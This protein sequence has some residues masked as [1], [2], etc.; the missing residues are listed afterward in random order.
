[1]IEGSIFQEDITFINIYAPNIRAPKYMKQILTELKIERDSSKIILGNFITSISIMYWTKRPMI[2]MLI[3][4]LN[5]TIDQLDLTEIY[6]ASH[7][8]T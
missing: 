6:S 1:M 7:P 5:K 2:N 8:T 4:Y 3:D